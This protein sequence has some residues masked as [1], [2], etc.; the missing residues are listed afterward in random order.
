MLTIFYF[1]QI[2]NIKINVVGM[3]DI[4]RPDAKSKVGEAQPNECVNTN[5]L[6][7]VIFLVTAEHLIN[8]K[9][10]PSNDEVILARLRD[11]K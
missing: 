1:G 7:L 5:R 4:F 10:N 2:R 11:K 3:T 9:L 8:R 6:K